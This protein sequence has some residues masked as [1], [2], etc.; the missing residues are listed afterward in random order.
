MAERNQKRPRS[1]ETT[2]DEESDSYKKVKM[3]SCWGCQND[4]PDQ[5]S[6]MDMGGCLYDPNNPYCH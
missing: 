2:S 6:H 4:A 1:T 5:R 3:E